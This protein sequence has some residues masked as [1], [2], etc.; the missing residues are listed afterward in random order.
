MQHF[1]LKVMRMGDEISVFP[2]QQYQAK[3]YTVEGDWS[4]AAFWYQLVTMQPGIQVKMMGLNSKTEQGDVQ[5]H[6]LFEKLGIETQ[7]G[8][9]HVSIK[10][11]GRKLAQQ[12][13]FDIKQMPDVFPA[14][15]FACVARRVPFCITGT[16]NLK[17]KESNRISAIANVVKQ[18]GVSMLEEADAV[19]VDLYPSEFNR[20]VNA[21][22]HGDHRIAM[23]AALLSVVIPE[24]SISQY[25]V[26]SKSYPEFWKEMAR[27][28]VEA[29]DS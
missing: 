22:V 7:F 4:S 9:Q 28:G 6:K 8:Q 25:E 19:R 1:G 27:V 21:D 26:V 24:V 15:V 29:F 20:R 18:M 13:N 23:S 17:L 12:V 16:A 3:P 5:M 2:G 11:T 10:A 14:L